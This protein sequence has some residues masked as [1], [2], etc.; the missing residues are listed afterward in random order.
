MHN[1][2][3]LTE[4]HDLQ[5]HQQA[6]ADKRIAHWFAENP[7]RFSE[8]SCSVGDLLLDYSKNHITQE[9]IS[10]LTE[11]AVACQLPKKI[12]ALFSGQ[13]INTTENRPAL[14]T[15]LRNLKSST[16]YINNHNIL[17]DVH[18]SLA[19]M[20]SFVE[21]VRAQTWLGSTGKPITDIINIGIGGSHLGPL[22]TTQALNDYATKQLRCHFISNID[23]IHLNEALSQLNPETA[24]FIVSSKSFTTL[25]T[26]TNAET[27]RLWLSQHLKSTQVHKHFVAVTAA[28]EKAKQFG[29]L[30]EQIFLLWDWVGGRYSIWSAIGLPLALM[31]GMDNFIEFLQGAYEMDQHFQTAPLAENMPVLMALLG[32]WY[33][34]FFAASNHVTAPY[35]HALNYLHTYLRQADMES[36]GKH[37]TL[38]GEPIDYL[39]GPI[40][41]GEQ[42]CDGQH[43]FYQSLHQGKHYIPVDFILVA[44]NPSAF[45]HHHDI[46]IA[47]ALSQA[48]ALMQGK[49]RADILLE[50]LA[51]GHTQESA[52][53][54]AQHRSIPGN[55]PSNILFIKKLTPFNLGALLALYEHKIFVQGVIWNIN[56]FDQWG[57]EL[58]KQLL[59]PILNALKNPESELSLDA[60]TLGLMNYYKKVRV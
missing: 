34:N 24:L 51:A 36:N 42:G 27:I 37:T 19:K 39:T 30:E 58:G 52:E 15:A 35:S 5:D 20:R 41:S 43:T 60:S 29:I 33:I 46:L 7:T 57:I 1:L 17:T 28:P 2:T 25:E 8:F 38:Q 50:L 55:R 31:I 49:A 6:I 45:Q 4:W 26:L 3:T 16:L 14:H 13:A 23:S 12:T 32:V 56:S 10:R 47:S 11:L 54:L 21:Q 18:A 44:E 9:T 48:Q 53:S 40:L 22:M 59:P